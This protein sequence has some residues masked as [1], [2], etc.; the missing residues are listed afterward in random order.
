MSA[1]IERYRAEL[2][3]TIDDL[4]KYALIGRDKLQAVR[5]EISAIKKVGLE[6]MKYERMTEL[7]KGNA[8]LAMYACAVVH[9]PKI[10]ILDE[11]QK[12]GGAVTQKALKNF[13]PLFALNYSA[14]HEKQHNLVYVLDALEA[15]NKVISLYSTALEEGW[16]RDKAAEEG[17]SQAV[18]DYGWPQDYKTGGNGGYAFMDIN[19]DGTDELLMMECPFETK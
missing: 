15:F 9:D 2:P 13:N 18:Y 5:A 1:E 8:R 12:M 4:A 14:T 3:A 7:S 17:L 19:N 10:L 16:D 6:R 11:P